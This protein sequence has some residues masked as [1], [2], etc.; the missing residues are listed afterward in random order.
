MIKI[1][2]RPTKAEPAN[3]SQ[4]VSALRWAGYGD[5]T[6]ISM[7]SL[8]LPLSPNSRNNFASM[9][10]SQ[11][12]ATPKHQSHRWRP[13]PV[14]RID[15][16]RSRQLVHDQLDRLCLGMRSY[17]RLVPT[18]VSRTD[19]LGSAL[20]CPLYTRR[21]VGHQLRQLDHVPIVSPTGFP[22]IRPQT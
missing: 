6:C 13:T 9:A 3:L 8:S 21:E 1:A 12:G 20:V 11:S 2:F 15:R 4:S 10:Q 18:P 19:R 5:R 17:S 14:R 16:V 22:P 7:L